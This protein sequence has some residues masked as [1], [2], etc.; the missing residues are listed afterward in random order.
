MDPKRVESHRPE[1]I[2]PQHRHEAAIDA[3]T[4]E[5]V[6][7]PYVEPFGRGIGKHH[8]VAFES[9]SCKRPRPR[10][11]GTALGHRA[12]CAGDVRRSAAPL[13]TTATFQPESA[14][15]PAPTLQSAR[16]EG[17]SALV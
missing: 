8:Q 2:V 13:S 6:H 11:L 9:A 3:G 12:E 16:A 7:V 5:S 10:T 1:Y 15:V 14:G 4:G 17:R